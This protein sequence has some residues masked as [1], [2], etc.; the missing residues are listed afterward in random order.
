VSIFYSRYNNDF[1][2]EI[3]L[4]DVKQENLQNV[5]TLFEKDINHYNDLLSLFYADE[6][7]IIKNGKIRDST[8][9][10]LI[11]TIKNTMQSKA[12]KEES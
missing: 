9:E 4:T 7:I 3:N 1:D 6:K 11:H 10:S 12:F 8:F 5:R 2:I